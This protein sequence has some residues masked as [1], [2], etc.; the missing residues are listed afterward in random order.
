MFLTIANVEI[1]CTLCL[2]N[3]V[4]HGKC[5]V[6]GSQLMVY[7]SSHASERPCRWSGIP[8]PHKTMFD[9]AGIDINGI[10]Y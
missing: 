8:L 10:S 9:L 5:A 2:T 3:A 1:Y 7:M 4:G 6:I